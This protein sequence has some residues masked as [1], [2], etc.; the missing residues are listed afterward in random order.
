[1]LSDATLT[2]VT[3]RLDRLEQIVSDQAT[4]LDTVILAIDGT[5]QAIDG[6]LEPS[7]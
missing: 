5:S 1:M 6:L 4:R 7:N 3:N 2:Q